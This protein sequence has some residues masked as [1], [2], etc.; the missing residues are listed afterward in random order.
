MGFVEETGVAQHYRDARIAAIYEGTTAIQANDLVGRKLLRD[1]GAGFA[2]LMQE[3]QQTLDDMSEQSFLEMSANTAKAKSELEKVAQFIMGNA[4]ESAIFVGAVAV[5]FLMQL[6]YVCGAWY[7]LRSALIAN[8]KI[9]D[10]QGDLAFY[11]QKVSAARFYVA[12]VLPRAQAHGAAVMNVNSA[13]LSA[14]SF[15]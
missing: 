14:D 11:Q 5:N 12:Q 7:H 2:A 3:I 6:G 1:S 9:I 13:V 10:Q 15:G 4:D 8:K